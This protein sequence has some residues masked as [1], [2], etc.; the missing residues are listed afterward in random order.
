[1]NSYAPEDFLSDLA[2]LKTN[3][4]KTHD[5]GQTTSDIIKLTQENQELQRTNNELCQAMQEQYNLVIMQRNNIQ[6]L[7]TE[8]EKLEALL[9]KK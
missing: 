4:F 9:G 5:S 6:A 1:M 7:R 3:Y 8:I 2:T